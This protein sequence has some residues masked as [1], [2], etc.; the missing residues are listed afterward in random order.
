MVARRRKKTSVKLKVVKQCQQSCHLFEFF[1]LNNKVYLA[2]RSSV[3][4]FRSKMIVHT[5]QK[6]QIKYLTETV[7]QRCSVKKVFL[8]ISQNPQEN[9]YARVSFLIKLQV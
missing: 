2:I 9:T 8:E 1:I 6:D 7:I 3:F 5:A 4:I